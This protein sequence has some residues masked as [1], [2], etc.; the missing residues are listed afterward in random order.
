MGKEGMCIPIV[1][2]VRAGRACAPSPAAKKYLMSNPRMAAFEAT[3]KK[4]HATHASGP[5]LYVWCV[6][7]DPS[8]QGQGIS[9]KLMRAAA[10][11]ADRE[12]LPCY[13]ET[14]GPKN[15]TIYAKYGYAVVGQ[16]RMST[17][18]KKGAE[19][20]VFEHPYLAMV[21]PKQA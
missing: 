19:P 2:L 16:D 1:A 17:K 13:L 12:G 20:E 3:L 9:G 14:C 21:R 18:P 5:H 6:A 11:I 10:S 7:I 4:L 15:P 8:A